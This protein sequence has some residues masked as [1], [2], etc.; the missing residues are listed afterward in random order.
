MGGE[1]GVGEE[2]GYRDVPHL[3]QNM[4]LENNEIHPDA[5]E[6]GEDGGQVEEPSQRPPQVG[7]RQCLKCNFPMNPH[8]RLLVSRFV[9][10]IWS[11]GLSYFPK[12]GR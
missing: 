8:V 6:D 12:K 11:V 7:H 1:E 3:K 5:G 10:L 4:F 2:V 9:G